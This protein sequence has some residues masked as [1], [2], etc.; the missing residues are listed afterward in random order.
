MNKNSNVSSKGLIKSQI[1]VSRHRSSKSVLL[2]L[3]N[4][5]FVP[6]AESPKASKF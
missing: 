1:A 4:H 6:V 2:D 5:S 3:S